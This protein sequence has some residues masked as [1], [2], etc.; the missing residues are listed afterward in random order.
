MVKKL[1]CYG[2]IVYDVCKCSTLYNYSKRNVIAA[3]SISN[4][5]YSDPNFNSFDQRSSAA[6]WA[7]R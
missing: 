7:V 5:S 4:L 3:L 1:L 2:N 6:C